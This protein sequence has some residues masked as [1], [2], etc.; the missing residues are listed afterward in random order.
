MKCIHLS[1]TLEE[2]AT[3]VGEEGTLVYG[4]GMAALRA[5]SLGGKNL[6]RHRSGIPSTGDQPSGNWLHFEH[7]QSKLEK[8]EKQ[9]H[10]HQGPDLILGGLAAP[11]RTQI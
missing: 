4:A 7:W 5:F 9:P 2:D 1:Y 3:T 11:V 8:P 10:L 6:R